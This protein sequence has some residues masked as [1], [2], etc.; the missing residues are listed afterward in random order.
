MSEELTIEG[1]PVAI[2]G[3]GPIGLATAAHLAARNRPFILLETGM[4]IASSVRA[5]S[6]VR[7]FTPWRYNTDIEAVRFLQAEGWE[8]PDP[9]S[10]PTGEE[11]I[12]EYLEPLA[13]HAAIERHIRFGARVLRITRKDR[14][15]LENDRERQPFALDL[16][17]GERFYASAVVD[18]SGSW[19]NP[20]PIGSD[21]Y[22]IPGELELAG[23]ITYGPPD[24]LG[25]ERSRYAGKRVLV[26][27]SGHSA[28]NALS[29]LVELSTNA[30][31]TKAIW[32]LRS[33]I[34]TITRSSC[35]EDG[36]TERTLLKRDV[37]EMV[38][39]RD[40]ETFAGVRI[41]YLESTD[42]GIVAHARGRKLPPVDEIIV[43][44]G[45]RPDH[46]ITQELR[47]D[48]HH[49]FESPHALAELIDPAV[50]ACG[51]V[52]P[53]SVS[54]ISHPELDF[55]TVGMKSYGRAPTFLLLTGYEQVRSVVCALMRDDAAFEIHLDLPERGLCSAC[56]A[57]LDEQDRAGGCSCSSED[58]TSSDDCC[59]EIEVEP[60]GELALR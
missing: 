8:H 35:D 53:H 34:E 60:A 57:Y 18:A 40:I 15:K 12:T 24:V 5:W 19:A 44:T 49:T 54:R 28:L 42:L 10:Y 16:E 1:L 59:S 45:F 9:G 56:T 3:A 37:R 27:G 20:N 43:A 29:H 52:P 4:S 48:L 50:N 13:R 6:H 33:D 26:I 2:V 25:T 23:N 51:T 21:G 32:A 58:G 41:D 36:L 38:T 7:L 11:F 22:P 47:L 17:S 30:T 14:G 46:R 31:G 55:F 39:S